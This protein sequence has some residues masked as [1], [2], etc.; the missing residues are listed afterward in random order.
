M[1]ENKLFPKHQAFELSVRKTLTRL[2]AEFNYTLKN[3][4]GGCYF[5]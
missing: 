1:K 2:T 3:E 5:A 4:K